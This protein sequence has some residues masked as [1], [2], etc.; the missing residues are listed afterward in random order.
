MDI[1]S[2]EERVMPVVMTVVLICVPSCFGFG[3]I[4]YASLIASLLTG[5]R[6]VGSYDSAAL[7]QLK[8]HLALQV[9]G[10]AEEGARR[11]NNN[12]ATGIGSRVNG[13]VDGRG[14]ECLA[15]ANCA[16]HANVVGALSGSR[17]G[18]DLLSRGYQGSCRKNSGNG[19]IAAGAQKVSPQRIECIH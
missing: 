16:I 4:V 1:F 18:T 5:H 19:T 14:V 17:R 9:N 13:A 10:E 6:R 7:L 12:A 11:K 3:R 2:P 15:V 8:V